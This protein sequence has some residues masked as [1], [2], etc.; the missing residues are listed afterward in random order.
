MN[1][2]RKLTSLLISS[3]LLIGLSACG[4]SSGSSGSSSSE[5][6]AGKSGS[7]SGKTSASKESFSFD[8]TIPETVIADEDEFKITALSLDKTDK[9]GLELKI[10][11]EN[12][13]DHELTFG[14]SDTDGLYHAVNGYSGFM[15]D[16]GFN[17]KVEAG[18]SMETEITLSPGELELCGIQKIAEMDLGFEVYE[19]YSDR[20]LIQ[21]NLKTAASD[22]DYSGESIQ[23]TLQDPDFIK[24]RNNWNV[25]YFSNQIDFDAADMKVLS[26]AVVTEK[27][28]QHLYI[29]VENS[30]DDVRYFRFDSLGINGLVYGGGGEAV[31]VPPG[32]KGICDTKLKLPKFNDNVKIT[33][34]DEIRTLNIGSFI[35]EEDYNTKLGSGTFEIKLSDKEPDISWTA[36]GNT[37]QTAGPP[38]EIECIGIY[39]DDSSGTPSPSFML[40]VTNKSGQILN[41]DIEYENTEINFKPAFLIT[42]DAEFIPD[43]ATALI[44]G[45]CLDMPDKPMPAATAD[46]I[47]DIVVNVLLYPLDENGMEQDPW[48]CMTAIY[49]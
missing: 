17:K 5:G 46:E 18:D 48:Y 41:A 36:A 31:Q 39:D 32:K 4:T 1:H 47:T 28:T 25:D 35:V 23:N 13:S 11:L 8:G 38:V 44:S 45:T 10:K 26:A 33:G 15:V 34:L 16:T 27:E 40:A 12:K 6:S 43:G 37:N 21:Y 3:L 20:N 42:T 29:E 14:T 49:K 19:N 2:C 30:S 9:G 22:Y 24:S 7:S